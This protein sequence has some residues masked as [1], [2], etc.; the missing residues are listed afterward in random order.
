MYILLFEVQL[1][2]GSNMQ[3]DVR[4]EDGVNQ[5]NATVIHCIV[6]SIVFLLS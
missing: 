6:I 5:M 1:N 2:Y 3:Y 4:S